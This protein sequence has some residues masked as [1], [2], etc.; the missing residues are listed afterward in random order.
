M[1]ALPSIAE[2]VA[3][4]DKMAE[5]ATSD[6]ERRMARSLLVVKL[7]RIHARATGADE[8]RAIEDALMEMRTDEAEGLAA[9]G[10]VDLDAIEA[11]RIE[12]G[13]EQARDNLVPWG[14]P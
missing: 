9:L 2:I 3:H 13:E 8:F 11:E 1:S 5:A 4:A 14:A 12:R 6:L 10:E 7:A